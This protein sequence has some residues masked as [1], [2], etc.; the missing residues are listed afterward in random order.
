MQSTTKTFGF[1]GEMFPFLAG[2]VGVLSIG[3]SY[4]L[5][6]SK[7]PPDVDPFPKTDITHCGINF[8]EYLPFRIGLLSI[9]PLFIICWYLTK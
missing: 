4:Y 1:R 7:S 3:S 5:A 6:R 2:F 8:P 9:I